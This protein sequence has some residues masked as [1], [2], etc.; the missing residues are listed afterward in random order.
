MQIAMTLAERI[1]LAEKLPQY[2]TLQRMKQ[3][4]RIRQALVG[5]TDAQ[6]TQYII[7]AVGNTF[8]TGNPTTRIMVTLDDDMLTTFAAIITE[9]SA[10]G[11]IEESDADICD[12]IINSITPEPTE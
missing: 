10:A 12:T 9:W 8:V 4:K 1:R 3:V 7:V 5:F 6:K 11:T 2:G